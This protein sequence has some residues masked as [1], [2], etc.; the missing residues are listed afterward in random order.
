MSLPASKATALATPTPSPLGLYAMC[1]SQDGGVGREF[2]KMSLPAPPLD[3][4]LHQVQ[5]P[6]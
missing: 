6:P 2:W 3:L 1:P 5:R 4:R